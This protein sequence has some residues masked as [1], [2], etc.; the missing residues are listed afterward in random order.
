M[1]TIYRKAVFFL[2]TALVFSA[3]CCTVAFADAGPKPVIYLTLKNAPDEPYYVDLL[4]YHTDETGNSDL[5][6]TS[7]S[8]EQFGSICTVTNNGYIYG[9]EYKEA[10]RNMYFY[11]EGGWRA[12]LNN[13]GSGQYI[14][15]TL[16]NS[17]DKYEFFQSYDKRV[18]FIVTAE[19]GDI[20]VS[21]ELNRTAF[22]SEVTFN[23]ETGECSED[24]RLNFT[25]TVMGVGFALLNTLILTLLAEGVVF[26]CFIPAN[27]KPI[28]LP[29]ILIANIVTQLFLYASLYIFSFN[30]FLPAELILTIAEAAAYYF[31]FRPQKRV[32]SIV[33]AVIAN[34]LS[35]I[36][37]AEPIVNFINSCL[38]PRL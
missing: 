13:I 24:T 33:Y 37:S 32:L 8:E 2:I 36:I 12:R 6:F 30:A 19:S 22:F 3:C 15:V 21:N 28:C 10:A 14:G 27:F 7:R 20:I 5:Y 29:V 31:L 26:L 23:C 16:C 9:V 17:S 34:L 18:R 1:K 35:I 25:E 11:S 38:V 4:L